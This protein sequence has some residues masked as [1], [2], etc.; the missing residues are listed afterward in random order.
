MRRPASVSGEIR[1]DGQFVPLSVGKDTLA[2]PSY[3]GG[4]EWGGPAI[5]PETNVLYINAN[6]YGSIAALA[7][8]EGGPPG[9]RTYLNQ[10][11]LC[12][13]EHREDATGFPLLLDVGHRLSTEQ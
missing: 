3:E 2:T 6:N 5:D 9:R 10:C 4:A 12:H 11:A 7:V 8:N 13:G 1:H